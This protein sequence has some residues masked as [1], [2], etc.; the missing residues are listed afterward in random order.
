MSYI[1][2]QVDDALREMNEGAITDV[3]LNPLCILFF[4]AWFS[5]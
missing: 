4:Y 2:I 3:R 1:Q 5:N